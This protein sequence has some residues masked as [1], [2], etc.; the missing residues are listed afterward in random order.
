MSRATSDG[1]GPTTSILSMSPGE[2]RS[3]AYYIIT[4]FPSINRRDNT[5][6]KCVP[7][8]VL[9]AYPHSLKMTMGLGLTVQY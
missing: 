2:K 9:S 8:N 5:V 6:I 7:I 3:V 1:Q 4:M